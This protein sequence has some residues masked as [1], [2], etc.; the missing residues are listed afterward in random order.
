MGKVEV[1]NPMTKVKRNNEIDL[2][3]VKN[4]KIRRKLEGALQYARVSYFLRWQ[5]PNFFQRHLLG[6]KTK[7]IFCIN[8]AQYEQALI[9][10][11]DLGL[12]EGDIRMIGVK[13]K[14]KYLY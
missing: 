6:K 9:V 5:E 13:S 7:L 10:I 11:E 8:Q 1:D 12:S 4:G 2:C 14:N 3:E